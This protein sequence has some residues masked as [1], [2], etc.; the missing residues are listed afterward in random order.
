VGEDGVEIT[1]TVTNTGDLA[2]GETVQVYV[3]VCEEGTPNAQLKGIQKLHLAAGES[4]VVELHLPKEAF[5]L[6]DEDG[7]L[8]IEEGTV[9]VYIGG[10][11][12]DSRSEQLTGEKVTEIILNV[13]AKLA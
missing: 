8:R 1:A 13:P 9:K 7:V 2:G 11:A 10:Q 4:T 5:G 6:Y 12:P 3:K